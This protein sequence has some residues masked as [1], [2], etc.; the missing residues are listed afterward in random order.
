VWTQRA[1]DGNRAWFEQLYPYLSDT[2]K[3]KTQTLMGNTDKTRALIDLDRTDAHQFEQIAWAMLSIPDLIEVEEL[4]AAY[5][6]LHDVDES[7]MQITT[8]EK[9]FQTKGYSDWHLD[10]LD[11][12]L[13]DIESISRGLGYIARYNTDA[14][15]AYAIKLMILAEQWRLLRVSEGPNTYRLATAVFHPFRKALAVRRAHGQ[16]TLTDEELQIISD[17]AHLHENHMAAYVLTLSDYNEQNARLLQLYTMDTKKFDSADAFQLYWRTDLILNTDQDIARV[18]EIDA[19]LIQ[20]ESVP[21]STLIRFLVDVGRQRVLPEQ[22]QERYLQHLDF[23]AAQSP[24][25]TNSINALRI[26]SGNYTYLDNHSK[27]LLD[28]AIS[29]LASEQP[30][31]S[32]LSEIYIALARQNMVQTNMLSHV[33]DIARRAL[34]DRIERRTTT[35][36]THPPMHIIVGA[37]LWVYTLAD[38]VALGITSDSSVELLQDIANV[39]TNEEMQEHVLSSIADYRVHHAPLSLTLDGLVRSLK[40]TSSSTNRSLVSRQVSATVL[41]KPAET[42]ADDIKQLVQLRGA[43]PEP[44]IRMAIGEALVRSVQ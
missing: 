22:I 42:R 12:S 19:W 33:E 2:A 16:K 20:N 13:Q 9:L 32:A 38:F 8:P 18:T 41:N 1:P 29:R 26:L 28:D 17:L 35:T 14:V 3:F 21:A 43:S 40:T 5:P 10:V 39:T 30:M 23:V 44:V 24:L 4:L 34:E 15:V 25:D 6:P 11:L 37:D 31:S 27:A 36:G 7:V